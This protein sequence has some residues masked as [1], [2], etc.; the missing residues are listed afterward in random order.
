ML[1][2]A[3]LPVILRFSDGQPEIRLGPGDLVRLSRDKGERLL[4]MAKHEV[5]PF[6]PDWAKAWRELAAA[7]MGITKDDNRYMEVIEA[8]GRCDAAFEADDFLMFQ[9][10]AD[11]VV[12][13]VKGTI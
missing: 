9:A 3:R 8:L 10:A 5:K 13:V 7:V 6:K 1:I 12:A 11:Q 2:Q 4:K